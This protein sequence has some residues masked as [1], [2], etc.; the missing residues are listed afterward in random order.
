MN[1]PQPAA[2]S[3]LSEARLAATGDLLNATKALFAGPGLVELHATAAHA[4]ILGRILPLGLPPLM[5]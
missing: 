3:V 5:P 4:A 2:S 1:V